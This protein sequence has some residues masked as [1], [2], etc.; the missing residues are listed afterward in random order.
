[1]TEKIDIFNANLEPRGSMERAEAHLTGR[2]HKTFHCWIVSNDSGGRFLFQ[3]RSAKM[4]NFPNLLDVSAAGH[5]ETGEEVQEGI[6]EVKEELGIEI[7]EAKL[8][9][10]GYRVEVADQKN[11][12]K[13]R[14]Y[15][16]VFLYKLENSK[17]DFIPQIE[18]LAGLYWINIS[19]ALSLFT[20]MVDRVHIEGISFDETYKIWKQDLQIVGLNDFLPR[21]QN[22]YLTIAI[23]AQRLVRGEFPLSIS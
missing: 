2:W 5:L 21:I 15:Q 8:Y 17:N 18:E 23:M 20:N 9:F 11:G 1:M 16:A 10:L 13:N 7:D 3:K 12:Q 19:D 6:R 22:Y 4:I 14:E